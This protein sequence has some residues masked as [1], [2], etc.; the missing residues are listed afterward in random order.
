MIESLQFFN[1]LSLDGLTG[2]SGVSLFAILF[3]A[4]FISEDAA[5]LTAGGLAASGE[6]SFAL[7]VS[8][9]F[10]G[11]VAGD[12]LLYWIGR[13]AG[14]R[15]LR[16]ELAGR[17]ISKRSL[18]NAANWLEKRGAS[19]VFVSRFITGLRL[20]TYLAAGV[21]KTNFLKFTLYFVIAAAIWTPILVGSAAF[22]GRFL[23]GNLIAGAILVFIIV[24]LAM[25]FASWRNRRIAIGKLKRITRWEFWPLPVFYIP[26]VLYILLLA[27]KHRSLTVFTCVN[28]S[29]PA[30][31][32]VGES[33]DEIYSLLA[34]NENNRRFLLRHRL[35]ASSLPAADKIRSARH[36]METHRLS[37][38]VVAKPDAGERGR[39]VRIIHTHEE[40]DLTVIRADTDLLIQEYFD[41]GEASV[42]YYRYPGSAKGRLFSIT[43]KVFPTVAG[44]GVSNLETLILS[45][46]RAICLA[47][48]YFEE[49][50]QRLDEVPERGENVE[51]IKIGTHSR[52]AIFRDGGRFRT[53]ELEQA[54]D[55]IC[56]S[57]DGFYFGRFDIRY[58]SLADFLAGRNF[59]IIELNGVTSES[60]NIYDPCSSLLDAY[61]ILFAQWRIAFE[62]G[63]ENRRR[64]SSP[65]SS[66]ELSRSAFAAMFA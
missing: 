16:S 8:A 20:P 17:F 57:I 43:E 3:F 39:G 37:F 40:L 22:A 23:I 35:I 33:K 49:N 25:R 19:A 54:I 4:T 30:G 52:G 14:T 55:A 26:V 29:I 66:L 47:E 45:D 56:R 53:T 7:A 1:Q 38:P 50:R 10:S 36:F 15:L 12:I 61:Q 28:P 42:F 2:L 11:I 46:P 18:E 6:T 27:I 34:S 64:G 32:F 5:C 58:S 59:K 41:G 62:I 51:L 21:L 13:I 65:T 48:K 44:N 24:R 63:A 9:C 31:G 60:T